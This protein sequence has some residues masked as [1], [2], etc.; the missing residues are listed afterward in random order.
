MKLPIKLND[1]K[2]IN[3]WALFDWANS[4]YSLVIATAIFPAYFA[5]V[6]D[7][8]IHIMGLEIPNSA[9]Y[10]YAVAFA[11]ILIAFASPALS[12]IADY[13]G[14]KKYFL[15]FFTTMGATACIAMF[16]FKGM[17]EL[18]LGLTAFVLATIGFAGGLVF[19]N[20]YLPEI[21]SEDQF[22]KVS[23]KGFAFGY[24]GSVILLLINLTVIMKPDWFGIENKSLPV[25]IAFIMVG[26]W[27]IG[28]SQVTFRYM[29]A[30][31]RT[32][33]SGNV[34][35][36][37]FQELRKV[38]NR[39]QHYP[40]TKRFL[41]A[42]FC[43]SA[44]VQ[45]V[46]YMASTFAEKELHFT[47]SELIAIIIILQLVAIGGAYLFA[48]FSKWKGN[49]FSLLTMLCVWILICVAAYTVVDKSQF[50]FVA[51]AVGLVMGGIQS[52]SRSTYSKLLPPGEEDTASFFSFYDVLEKSA[53]VLGTFSFGLIE[54][55]TGGMRNSVLALAA[56]FLIGIIIISR[57]DLHKA[58]GKS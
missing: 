23:A 8:I 26:L 16:Y 56:F 49:K 12:G 19:Y 25:R 2:T 22:D 7:P 38:W 54:T 33:L 44:G 30:D 45:T 57:T 21:A 27:W 43:Y 35:N 48:S 55:M 37:G 36:R 32:N 28:F 24:I 34:V 3:A 17:G 47:T 31:K 58:Y 46:L 11:Y 14:R 20:S 1:K 13:S 52:L 15:R 18:Y 4:S 10:A 9:L 5:S 51:A 50:Y 29:P 40:N 39:I 6:T 53:I 42:F 41:L